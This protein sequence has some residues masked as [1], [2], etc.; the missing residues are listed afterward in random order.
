[1]GIESRYCHSMGMAITA[2][3]QRNV[4]IITRSTSQLGNILCFS[5]RGGDGESVLPQHG[6]HG[7]CTARSPSHKRNISARSCTHTHARAHARAYAHTHVYTYT[8]R[9]YTYTYTHA[10]TL[11]MCMHMPVTCISAYQ[12]HVTHIYP[13]MQ[14]RIHVVAVHI[15]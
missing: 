11:D 14:M 5:A 9:T 15:I 10:H 7:Q 3:V 13:H 6:D 2:S 1:M 4:D 8:Y 12:V